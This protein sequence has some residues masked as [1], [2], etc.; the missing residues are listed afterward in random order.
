VSFPL[1]LRGT[2]H[3]FTPDGK[4]LITSPGDPYFQVWDWATG[5]EKV[6]SAV[7]GGEEA[8]AVAVSPDGRRFATSRRDG[9]VDVWETATG[10]PAVALATHRDVV[11][12]VSVSPDG[13]L[14]ATLGLDSSIRIWEVESGKPGCVV[15]VSP[16]RKG[17]LNPNDLQHRVAFTP[18]GRLVF[19]ADDEL[20]MA[21]P[22]TGARLDV[23]AGMR[24][25]RGLVA[26][27]TPDGK[28]LATFEG[29]TVTL[30]DWPAG[31]A[32][33]A[34][35]VRFRPG[36]RRGRPVRTNPPRRRRTTS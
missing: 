34:V 23:P 22:V 28:T 3:A 5:A 29:D 18:E 16:T 6:R 19:T 26:G 12:A 32:R 30:W 1:A 33:L 31:T 4:A 21:D 14:A 7:P 17:R 9:R 24:G 27:F 36:T 13:R 25:R 2:G 10:R 15:P 8:T 35:T 11:A 20:A